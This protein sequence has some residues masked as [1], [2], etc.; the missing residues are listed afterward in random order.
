MKTTFTQHKAET[1]EI[2]NLDEWWIKKIEN[3]YEKADKYW[4]E[5]LLC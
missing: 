1:V 2:E 5:C 4:L 3:N